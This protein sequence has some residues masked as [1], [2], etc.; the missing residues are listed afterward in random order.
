MKK[1]VLGFATCV[2]AAA[3]ANPLDLVGGGCSYE[4]DI[5]KADVVETETH[6]AI[7]EGEEGRFYV[8]KDTLGEIPPIGKTM[9][10]K[11]DQIT[12]GTCTPIIYEVQG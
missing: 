5:I 4:T 9:I 12:K 6:G 3:C 2:M 7:F 10:L 11:R 8:G 1:S